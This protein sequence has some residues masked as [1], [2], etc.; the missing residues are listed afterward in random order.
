MM[1]KDIR[2]VIADVDGTLV[3]QGGH[4]FAV[5]SYEFWRRRFGADPAILGRTIRLGGELGDK[6]YFVVGVA[7]G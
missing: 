6:S 5:L 3:T 2:L 1:R 4:P 7:R